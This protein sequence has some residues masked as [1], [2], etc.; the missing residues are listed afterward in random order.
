M[1]TLMGEL[2]NKQYNMGENFS[3]KSNAYFFSDRGQKVLLK[4]FYFNKIG[5][6]DQNLSLI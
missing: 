3:Q 2:L 4:S 6:L 5:Q 1:G